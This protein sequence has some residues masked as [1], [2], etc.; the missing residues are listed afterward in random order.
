MSM[1]LENWSEREAKHL[2]NRAGFGG[3]PDEISEFRRL[4]HEQ[5]VDR[6]FEFTAQELEQPEWLSEYN[7]SSA[8]RFRNLS[9]EEKQKVRR[10]NRRHLRE[11]QLD[12]LQR[13]IDSQSTSDMLWE[14]MTFFWHSHF[15]TSARKVKLVPLLFQQ[16]STMHRHAIGNFR[17]FLHDMVKDP[18]LLR[19]LDNNQ[20]HKGKPNENFARELMEL[21][22][23]GRGHYT[24]TDVKESARAFTGWTSDLFHFNVRWKQHD[25]DEKTFLG[26]SG[27]FDGNDIAEII[28]EQPA[29]AEFI[30]GK[31]LSF[32]GFEPVDEKDITFFAEIFRNSGYEISVLLKTIFLNQK[33]YRNPVVGNQIKSPLQLV[34]GTARTLDLRMPHPQFYLHVLDLMGQVPY[35]PPNVKGWPGDRAWINTSRLL[36]RF[37]F[38]EIVNYGE[39]PPE[40]IP[41]GINRKQQ[42]D[43]KKKA[44]KKEMPR[45]FR[46]PHLGIEYDPLSLVDTNAPQEEVVQR[47]V[48]L[49]VAQDMLTKSERDSLLRHFQA[50]VNS[51]G[52][53]VGIKRLIGDIMILPAYQLG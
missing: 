27:R 16:L 43:G 37:T 7:A 23:L 44:G 42:K 9:R 14:K 33:F 39:I 53:T 5:S 17:E 18:A 25:L 26:H 19:Y 45:M 47:I 1:S 32:F 4:G 28:L 34:V 36:A 48:D 31:I 41:N 15:A 8:K 13:M 50:N 40:M 20:N 10:R 21:F 3:R 51:A 2:L 49:F 30:T 24:E 12:W 38:G 22:T 6:L 29:C 11:F 46:K 52:F 35:F